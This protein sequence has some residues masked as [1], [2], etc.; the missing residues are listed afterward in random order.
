MLEVNDWNR[1]ALRADDW[2][3]PEEVNGAY[4]KGHTS[5][6]LGVD[7]EGATSYAA[8]IAS[9]QRCHVSTPREGFH[10]TAPRHRLLRH[11]MAITSMVRYHDQH[12]N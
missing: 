6:C 12:W 2:D 11:D 10:T 1:S 7:T 4:K 8:A 5:D 9:V 3:G